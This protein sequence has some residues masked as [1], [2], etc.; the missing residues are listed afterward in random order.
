MK[1]RV[2]NQRLAGDLMLVMR[3]TEDLLKAT[4]GAAGDKVDELR[5][6]LAAKLESA[7]ATCGRLQ[8]KTARAARAADH[9]IREHPLESLGLALG[10][11]LLIG[12][13]AVRR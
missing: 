12:V 3:D 10:V 4:A 2:A 5:D 8:A 9:V 1:V 11:G 13:L 7:K 6:R